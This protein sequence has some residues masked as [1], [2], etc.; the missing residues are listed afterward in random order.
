MVHEEVVRHEVGL[1]VLRVHEAYIHICI[2][3]YIYICI[4]P[5]HIYIYIVYVTKESSQLIG[6][7]LEAPTP[8]MSGLVRNNDLFSKAFIF[9]PCFRAPWNCRSIETQARGTHTP[10]PPIKSLDFR[11]FDSSKLLILKGGNSHVRIT[12]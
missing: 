5:I 8:K 11:G 1:E 12:S 10:S 6:R 2:Y 3:I 4:I 7:T 9:P